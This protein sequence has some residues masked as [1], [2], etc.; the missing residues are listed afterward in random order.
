MTVPKRLRSGGREPPHW[1]R[2]RRRRSVRG[3]SGRKIMTGCYFTTGLA[4][5][6][7]WSGDRVAIPDYGGCGR[8][9]DVQ[10]AKELHRP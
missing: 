1:R 2:Y 4:G 10:T 6:L 5:H 9:C 7:E 3:K 8:A